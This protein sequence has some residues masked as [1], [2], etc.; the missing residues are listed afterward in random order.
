MAWINRHPN[1]VTW[2][3]LSIGMVAIVGYSARDVDTLA[4]RQWFWLA[5]AT[6]LVAGL[7]AWIISWEADEPDDDDVSGA[8]A[9]EPGGEA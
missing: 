9:P 2:A 7:C 6:V 5:F 8:E 1:L 4:G 3:V